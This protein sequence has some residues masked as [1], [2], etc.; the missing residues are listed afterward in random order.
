MPLTGVRLVKFGF[1]VRYGMQAD[2][3]PPA[4]C[5]DQNFYK[6]RHRDTNRIKVIW[7]RGYL[8]E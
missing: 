8:L 2:T 7:I 5:V 4:G 6:E 3:K 1:S